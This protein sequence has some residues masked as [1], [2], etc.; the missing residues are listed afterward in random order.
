M[1]GSLGWWT[2]SGDALIEALRRCS[3][4]EDADLVYAELYV[5]SDHEYVPPSGG[6]E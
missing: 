4:G 5:N 1:T 2:I 6:A 3:A